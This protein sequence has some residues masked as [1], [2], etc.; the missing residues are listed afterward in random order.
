MPVAES[1]NEATTLLS[2]RDLKVHFDLGSENRS[3]D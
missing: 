1:K 2:I 3:I